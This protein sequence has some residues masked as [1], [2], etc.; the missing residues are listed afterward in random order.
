MDVDNL[1]FFQQNKP[2]KCPKT[3]YFPQEI[4]QFPMETTLT[5]LELFKLLNSSKNRA[6]Q[7]PTQATLQTKPQEHKPTHV[8]PNFRQHQKTK[9][10]K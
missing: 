7:K 10:H 8:K 2:E 6:A 3:S 1:R 4:P 9:Q 5:L